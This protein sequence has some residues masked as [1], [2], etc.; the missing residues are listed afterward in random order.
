MTFTEAWEMIAAARRILMT[1]HV[2]PDGDGLGSMAALAE[3]LLARGKE[4]RV[5]LP[6]PVPPKYRFV[7]GSGAFELLGRDVTLDGLGET[8]DLV[9]I[10]DTCS[11]QQLEALRTVVEA[12]AGRILVIDHHAT[13]D[14]LGQRSL[15]DAAAAATSP[16][17]L[18][19][20]ESA[21]IAI[22][23]TMAESLF[24]SLASDTGWFQFP[25]VTPEVFRLAGRLQELGAVPQTIYEQLFQSESP[26]KMHLLALAL[27]TLVI[28]PEGDVASFHISRQMFD[29]AGA[30][31][32]DTENLINE[33]QRIAGVTASILCVEQE[34]NLIKVSLR[35]KRDVDMAA[36]AAGFG[37]GG[38][39]RAAGCTLRTS[40]EEARRRVLAAVR[41]A[42]GR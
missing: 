26:A 38:H 30:E 21:G 25:S 40:L 41:A 27:P 5:V 37:G 32:H 33:A 39:A 4:V 24:V 28:E 6:S 19:L 35:S 14:D 3:V 7:H 42:M 34:P 1:T 15:A 2:K 11:W 10:I 18:A 9:L 8:W 31:A 29:R 17:V 12:N 16:I 36:V 13:S 23:P 20:L 22:T